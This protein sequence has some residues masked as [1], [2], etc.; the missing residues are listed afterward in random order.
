MNLKKT[1]FTIWMLLS[2]LTIF[3]SC[4]GNVNNAPT[5]IK[6]ESN[7]D[8]QIALDSKATPIY[9]DKKNNLWFASK[10]K[11]VYKYDG[12]TFEKFKI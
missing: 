12:D 6:K 10:E 7:K 5:S 4:T 8:D 9:Q 11:G 3:S 2:I 1:H